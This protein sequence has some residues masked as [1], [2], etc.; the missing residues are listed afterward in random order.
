MA[1]G[2]GETQLSVIAMVMRGAMIETTLGLV[3]GVPTALFCARFVQ[4]Q[5][6]EVKSMDAG[7]LAISVLTLVIAASAAALIPARRAAS[8]D[9]A[10]AVRME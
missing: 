1:L 3:I 6:Y 5:L 4:T 10:H 9:P 7:I 2:R 8:I